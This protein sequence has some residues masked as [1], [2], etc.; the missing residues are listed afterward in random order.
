MLLVEQG[1]FRTKIQQP[2][3][4]GLSPP[5][6]TLL[7]WTHQ[8]SLAEKGRRWALGL[9]EQRMSSSPLAPSGQFSS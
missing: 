8:L 5:Q 1:S 3:A 2:M 4:Q 9:M 7:L 6:P